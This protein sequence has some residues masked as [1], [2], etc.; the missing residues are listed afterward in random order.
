MTD[1]STSKVYAAK[2]VPHARVSKPHQREKVRM[3]L[4]ATWCMQCLVWWPVACRLFDCSHPPVFISYSPFPHRLTK[5]LNFIED[6]I[7]KILFI[8][9]IILKTKTTYTFFWNTVVEEWVDLLN[10][11]KLLE[12]S[13]ILIPRGYWYVMLIF[14]FLSYSH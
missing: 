3:R 5:K 4:F 7:I 1:L 12:F 14:C 8:S 10:D 9:I 2:I 6:F 11:K 13:K